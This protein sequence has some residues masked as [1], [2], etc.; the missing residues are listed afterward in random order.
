MFEKPGHM[1]LLSLVKKVCKLFI[2]T[3]YII[4]WFRGNVKSIGKQPDFIVFEL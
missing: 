4:L 1:D 2:I 3:V